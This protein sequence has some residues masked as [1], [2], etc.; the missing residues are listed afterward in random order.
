MPLLERQLRALIEAGIEASD[1]LVELGDREPPALPRDVAA[2][3][4]LRWSRGSDARA[5]RLARAVGEADG[6]PVLAL[7]ADAVV[8]PRLLRHVAERTDAL[9]VRS[10]PG[11]RGTAVLRL[12]GIVPRAPEDDARLPALADAGVAA[13]VLADCPADAVPAYLDGLRRMLRVSFRIAASADLTARAF[14]ILRT[15]RVDRLTSQPVYP[16]WMAGVRLLARWRVT[17]TCDA[18]ER[19]AHPGRSIL[20]LR[21]GRGPLL[22]YA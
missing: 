22:A 19:R 18:A 3:L 1:V 12:C 11:A 9:A 6:T 17:R 20:P 7:E 13:G 2:R 21:G 16:R 15:T 14:P 10:D 8:D 4:P 5:V